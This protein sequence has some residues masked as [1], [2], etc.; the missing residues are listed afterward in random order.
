MKTKIA[1]GIFFISSILLVMPSISAIQL[2]SVDQANE[3]T[4]YIKTQFSRYLDDLPSDT[5]PPWFTFFYT[6]IMLSLSARIIIVTPLAITPTGE[7][8]GYFE[9][10]SYFFFLI[11]LTLVYRFAFWYTLFEKIA[12][13]NNWDIPISQMGV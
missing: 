6:L 3:S 1:I 2:I 13:I 9:I 4:A 8:W 10:N 12:E 7:Y 5:P 11:L